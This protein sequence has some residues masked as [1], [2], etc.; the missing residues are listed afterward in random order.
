MKLDP[1]PISDKSSS[2][3]LDILDGYDASVFTTWEIEFLDS[4]RDLIET[5]DLSEDQHA[6][7]VEIYTK[8]A[9]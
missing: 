4:V 7:L 8:V 9:K 1:L 2:T 5:E 6:K 3:L